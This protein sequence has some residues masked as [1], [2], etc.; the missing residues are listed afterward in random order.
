MRAT[1]AVGLLVAAALAAAAPAGADPDDL[2][3]YYSSGQV[4]TAGECKPQP[5]AVY[6]DDAPGADPGVPVGLDPGTVPAV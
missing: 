2:T 1:T 4:P 5:G 3:P 6:T